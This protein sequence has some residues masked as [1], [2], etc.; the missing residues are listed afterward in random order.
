LFFVLVVLGVPIGIALGLTAI[1]FF[2]SSGTIPMMMLPQR[3]IVGSTGFIILAVPFFILAGQLMNTSGVTRRIFHFADC[4]VGHIKGGL[5][6]VNIIAS[7]IFSGMSGSAIADVAGLG[8]VE[9]AAMKEKGFDSGFSAAVT[10]ASGIIGPIVPPSSPLIIFGVTASVSVGS[11]FIAGFLPGLV[12]TASLMIVTYLLAIKNKYPIRKRAHLPELWKA[13]KDSFWALMTPAVILGG[14]F[15]GIFT[16]T[17]AS[18][19]AVVYTLFIGLVIYKEI[20]IKDIPA[21]FGDVANETGIVILLLAGGSVFGWALA[22]EQIPGMIAKLVLSFSSNAVAIM[23]IIN[24]LLLLIGCF[25]PP[26]P[27]ILILGPIL[28]PIVTE[29]GYSPIHFGIIM[30]FN[31]MIGLLTPPVGSLIY[32]SARIARISFTEV[33][34]S[35]LYFYPVLFIVLIIITFVPELSLWLPG[36]LA[37]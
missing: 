31:L 15:S 5:G 7:L 2:V 16:P 24:A 6:H 18:V 36:L 27:V 1:I 13:F 25:M 8:T 29:L 10:A 26:V 9:I 33:I 37:K 19:V 22:I 20:K 28:L 30:V 12:L 32:V 23:L 21:I 3:M 34:K 35:L 17:E 11:L 4:L 14:I